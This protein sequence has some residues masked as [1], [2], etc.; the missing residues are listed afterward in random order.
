MGTFET[1]FHLTKAE[2]GLVAGPAFWG[3]T[4]AMIFGGSFVDNI[5]MNR[6]LSLAFIGHITGVL[7]TIFATGF[8]TLFAGTLLVGIGNGLV[9]AAC[10][11][12]V[13]SSYTTEKTKMLNR[14]HM[15]FPGGIVIGG[16]IGYFLLGAGIDWKIL[17][18]TMLI[19]AAI[20]GFLFFGQK[21][22]ETER[23][24][25]GVS[26]AD[27][28]KACFSSPLFLFMVACMFLTAGTELGTG[29]W[30]EALLKNSGVSGILVLVMINGIMAVGRS[31]AG[32]IVHKLNP[33]GMLLFSAIFATLG[34]I[35][36]SYAQSAAVYGAAAFFAAGVCYFWP[37]M[38]G[39]VSEYMPKTGAMGLSIMGGAGMLSVSLILPLMGSVYDAELGKAVAAIGQSREILE[40]AATGTAEAA[41]WAQVNLISGS[42]TLRLVAVMP[43]FLILAFGA[44]F[45]AGKNSK[46]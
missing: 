37:T 18:G 38:L 41:Q 33:A 24:A 44:L 9:E 11:P 40:K 31:F 4:L 29:Q 43:A 3:F 39:Y 45:F 15:W 16:L 19:P 14:F 12:L 21:F 25:S 32:P 26:M 30:I 23:V 22:P 28:F 7:L 5:G 27:M 13:A 36:L 42:N 46:A 17:Q 10:N 2:V 8:S 35:A 34:L 20:Y 6:L 1:E